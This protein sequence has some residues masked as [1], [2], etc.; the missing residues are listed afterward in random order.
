[1]APEVI[2]RKGY[3]VAFDYW[4]LGILLYELL[5]E[6]VPFADEEE[7][8]MIIY[9]IILTSKLRY[10]RLPTSMNNVKSIINQ[11]LNKNPSHRMGSGFEKL[12]TSPWFSMFSWEKL[13]SKELPAPYLPKIKK[14]DLDLVIETSSKKSLESVFRNEEQDEIPMPTSKAPEGWDEEF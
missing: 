8:P 3:G 6:R 9:E 1:M 12:K 7:D 14:F 13:L 5:F 4:S 2:L 10:P 11:L